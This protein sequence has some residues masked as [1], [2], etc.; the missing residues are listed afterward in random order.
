MDLLGHCSQVL[1]VRTLIMRRMFTRTLS[2]GGL[3]RPVA[4]VVASR[5]PVPVMGIS[6][7]QQGW[8]V[9]AS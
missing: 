8:N 9:P 4:L 2:A 3:D 6:A 5:E 7:G 1:I